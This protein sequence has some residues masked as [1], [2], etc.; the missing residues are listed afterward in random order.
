MV[1]WNER[2]L[3]GDLYDIHFFTYI[4]EDQTEVEKKE[5]SEFIYCM[6]PSRSKRCPSRKLCGLGW[7]HVG[8]IE[9]G[10]V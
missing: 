2:N 7:R 5:M 3:M 4:R 9:A 10:M 1:A 6:R 8:L